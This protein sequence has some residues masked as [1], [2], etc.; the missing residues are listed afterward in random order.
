MMTGWTVAEGQGAAG[1]ANRMERSRRSRVMSPDMLINCGSRG[2]FFLG[3]PT[4][5]AQLDAI[6]RI[7]LRSAPSTPVES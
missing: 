7:H 1:M 6:G 5:A 2:S 3:K 4:A